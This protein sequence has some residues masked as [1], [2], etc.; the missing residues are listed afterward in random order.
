MRRRTRLFALGAALVFLG[1]AL[2]IGLWP[3][4]VVRPATA[5]ALSSA[6]ESLAGSIIYD[7]L[8]FWWTRLRLT[9]VAVRDRRGRDLARVDEFYIRWDVWALANGRVVVPRF[10]VMRPWADLRDGAS[11]LRTALATRGPED[12]KQSSEPMTE[13]PT[14]IRVTSLRIKD[15][16]AMTDFQGLP[17][18]VRVEAEVDLSREGLAVASIDLSHGND[19]VE[20]STSGFDVFTLLGSVRARA[21]LAEDTLR[22]FRPTVACAITWDAEIEHDAQWRATVALNA[23]QNS[24]HVQSVWT[25]TFEHVRSQLDGALP[26]LS[27]CDPAAPEGPLEVSIEATGGLSE[28]RGTIALD[29]DELVVSG[30]PVGRMKLRAS[31]QRSATGANGNVSVL[32]WKHPDAPQLGGQIAEFS[33]KQERLTIRGLEV[34]AQESRLKADAHFLV[35][36]PLARGGWA[37]VELNVPEVAGW[38]GVLKKS[39]GKDVSLSGALRIDGEFEMRERLHGQG[40]IEARAL[41]LPGLPAFDLFANLEGTRSAV[42]FDARVAGRKRGVITLRGS[43]AA[44]FGN[45]VD[46]V[47]V[48]E[49]ARV[50]FTLRDLYPA[51]WGGSALGHESYATADGEWQGDSG[52]VELAVN[53]IEIERA[54]ADLTGTVTMDSEQTQARMMLREATGI[55]AKLDA[56]V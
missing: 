55:A 26:D 15:A 4:L 48:L 47:D 12:A 33:L 42:R 10:D 45:G 24:V 22:M 53:A 25:D 11:E 44:E 6:N 18:K 7:G 2:L 34:D 32:E 40:A 27:V 14:S 49:A 41:I 56:S 51:D 20:V 28:V 54:R 5:L 43:T 52:E 3:N 50:R 46:V 29:A 21:R 37:N 19:T 30:A 16:S 31:A 1:G 8:D 36:A 13:L 39:G 9:G 35:N 38:R 17:K 23:D